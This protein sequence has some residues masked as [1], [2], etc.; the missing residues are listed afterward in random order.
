MKFKDIKILDD[1]GKYTSDLS[2]V[3]EYVED[4]LR[5][6]SENFPSSCISGFYSYGEFSVGQNVNCQLHNQTL[7]LIGIQEK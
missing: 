5:K 4:E 1:A 6:V 2:I 7:T 3:F